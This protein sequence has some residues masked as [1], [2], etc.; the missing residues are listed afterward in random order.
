MYGAHTL[1]VDVLPCLL[2]SSMHS[3]IRMYVGTCI[4]CSKIQKELFR[5][6]LMSFF[7]VKID[8]IWVV[9]KMIVFVNY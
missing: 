4:R 5:D 3:I 1:Y 9:K 6:E 2:Y 7:F 8:K